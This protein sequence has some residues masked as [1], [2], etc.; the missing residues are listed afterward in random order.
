LT[1]T[2]KLGKI[3]GKLPDLIQALQGMAV[4]LLD[5]LRAAHPATLDPAAWEGLA[6]P[7]QVG[8]A[9]LAGIDLRL[10]RMRAVL[11]AL[12][13][14]AAAPTGFR[15]QDLAQQVCAQTGWDATRYARRHAAYDL[16]KIRGKGL[17]T[18]IGKTRRY[19]LALTPATPVF[20]ALLLQEQIMTPVVSLVAHHASTA[21][22]EPQHELDQHYLTLYQALVDTMQAFCIAA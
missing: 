19:Q 12:G 3:L 20:A 10:P 5:V 15:I 11:H 22:R 14:L 9:R 4:R 7:S 2:L 6:R 17:I 1:L 21:A 13:A 8:P 16:Q 18:R